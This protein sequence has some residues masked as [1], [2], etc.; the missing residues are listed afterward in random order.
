TGYTSG[1]KALNRG[2]E[3]L[4][5]M[6]EVASPSL[7]ELL[8]VKAMLGRTIAAEDDRLDAPLAVVLSHALWSNQF[9]QDPGVLGEVIKLSDSRYTV[10]GVMPPGFDHEVGS[11]FWLP[12]VPTLDPSTRPS[13]RSITVIGR[14]APGATLAGLRG[15]LA[16]IDPGA[17]GPERG[18]GATALRLDA[19]PLRLRYTSST[20]S[21]DLAFAVVVALVLLIAAAN[22]VNLALV[23]A[24][25]VR[26]EFAVRAALGA[27]R[28]RIARAL[29]VQHALLVTV[30]AGLG[31]LF[32]H[33]LLGVLASLEVMQSLRPSGMEYRLDGR[34]VGFA[35]VLG[36]LLA[37]VLSLV[38][39]G[40]AA[41]TDAQGVLRD[42]G[43][44][45]TTGRFGRWLQQGVV[46]AQ[47]V[48]AVVLL[49]GGGLMAKTV[50]R[51][52]ATDLGF[53][54]ARLIQGT[55]SFPHPWRVPETYRP[56]TRQIAVDLGLLPGATAV[57]FRASVPLAS[58]GGEPRVT[59]SGAAEPLPATV[60]PRALFAIGGD[61][62]RTLGVTMA[63]GRPIDDRDTEHSVAVAM[64]NEWAARRWWPGQEAVGK[65]LRIDTTLI[66]VV[67]VVRDNRA[68][69]AGLLLADV[70]PEIYRP[71]EQISSPYPSFYV[72][73][74]ADAG[75]L[76]KPV[77]DVL[78]RSVPDRPLSASLVADQVA[79]QLAGVRLNAIQI[80]GFALV[81]LLLAVIGVH[82]VLAFAVGTRTQEIGVRGALGASRG[83]LALMVV[84][85][86]ARLTAIGLAIGLPLAVSATT[87]IEG[88]LHG[89]SRSDPWVYGV[90]ALL[91][92]VVVLVS[93]YLPA[94]RAA[95]IDPASA[96]RSA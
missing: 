8:G 2:G 4:L 1:G 7:F 45:S 3:P 55:P 80:L 92:V 83:R 70:S 93:S 76:L 67:G 28:G 85:D 84:R 63:S 40:L 86:A 88:L 58:A 74:G 6:G 13:I 27:A 31:L 89:T 64:V 20:Q 56:V 43:S 26:R 72:R 34:A 77:R 38:P 37:W 35:L 47:L 82:G 62:L 36:V 71:F 57:A 51:L 50:L 23:R 21:H 96:L 95:R 32:A 11:Q 12:M 69:Q 5:V 53:E 49:V 10:I 60:V 16:G 81:G 91:L 33:W 14:L 59:L 94:R 41:R 24:L 61:Y 68:A 66:T 15:E 52:G 44:A 25:R 65:V 30:A 9:G 73:A 17:L 54:P 75:P 79:A 87:V 46:V 90:V 48:A 29:F 18:S 39:A 42:G 78:V 22:V 19:A